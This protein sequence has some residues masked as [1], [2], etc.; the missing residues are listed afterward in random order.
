MAR[1]GSRRR[2][3]RAPRSAKAVRWVAL[4]GIALV[5]LL[6]YR[7]VHTYL[8]KRDTLAR[9]SAEVRALEARRAELERRLV[10]SASDATLLRE[11]RKLGLVRPG[12]RLFIVTGIGEW[13]RSLRARAK[14][15]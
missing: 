5:G 1:A 14:H 11:A 9:R 3:R 15:R 10:E 6:Y 4:A 2:G 13:R 8:E 7:P 12:E